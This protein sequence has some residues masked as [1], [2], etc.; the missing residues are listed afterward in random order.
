MYN[1]AEAKEYML[2]SRRQNIFKVAAL[3]FKSLALFFFLNFCIALGETCANDDW[4][5]PRIKSARKL[6][7]YPYEIKAV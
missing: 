7:P 3:V 5:R 6:P 4:E 2:Y 1:K